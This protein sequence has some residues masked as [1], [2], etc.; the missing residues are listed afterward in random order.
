MRRIF[1]CFVS[2]CIVGLGGSAA[3]AT[4]IPMGTYTLTGAAADGYTLTGDLTFGSN[5]Y[6][7][8]AALRFNDAAVGD[9]SFTHIDSEGGP[10]GYDPVADYAYIS[11][12]TGQVALYY[13]P[14]LTASGDIELCILNVSCNAYQASYVQIYSPSGFDGNGMADLSSGAIDPVSKSASPTPEPSSLMLLGTGVLCMAG[15]ARW[16][17]LKG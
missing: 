10:A 12:A 11:G 3:C 14:T 15:V 13:L 6:V 9:P 16:R 8:A 4:P 7:S 5:G 17:L 2:L 1:V